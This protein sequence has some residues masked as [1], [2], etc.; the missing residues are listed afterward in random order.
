MSYLSTTPHPQLSSF[1]PFVAH[2]F[3][4]GGTPPEQSL[5]TQPLWGHE[6]FPTPGLSSSSQSP[7]S[8]PM[9]MPVAPI[10][11][12][13]PTFNLAAQENQRLVDSIVVPLKPKLYTTF[14]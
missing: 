14:A 12:P 7:A 1:D 9:H 5:K 11:A 3:T 6:A 10:H 8:S 2:P 4:S 13:K